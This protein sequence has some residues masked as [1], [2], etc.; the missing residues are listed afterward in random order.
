MTRICFTFICRRRPTQNRKR[1]EPNGTVYVC[2]KLK[3]VI[4]QSVYFCANVGANPER[5]DAQTKSNGREEGFFLIDQMDGGLFQILTQNIKELVRWLKCA[6]GDIVR[7][8][9][10][11]SKAFHRFVGKF[12]CLKF[13]A[14]DLYLVCLSN[15][16]FAAFLSIRSFIWI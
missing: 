16:I 15:K 9:I 2:N 7:S 3:S 8:M 13:Q 11:T 5:R 14:S 1:I 4:P 12:S 6:P 10:G